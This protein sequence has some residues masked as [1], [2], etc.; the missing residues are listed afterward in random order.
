MKELIKKI[1]EI[2]KDLFK[3]YPFSISLSIL[4]SFILACF[5]ES[6]F[7]GDAIVFLLVF[8]VGVLFSEICFS[9]KTSLKTT[10]FII[11]LI[12]AIFANKYVLEG[13]ELISK[14]TIIYVIALFILGLIKY[15]K[16]SNLSL[17]EYATRVWSNLFK[18]HLVFSV[19][20][21][22]IMMISLIIM[23][24]FL[25][26]EQ[27]LLIVRLELLL[28]GIYYVPS[29]IYSFD[30]YK[31]KPWDF[32]IFILKN[33]TSAILVLAFGI[34]YLYMLKILITWN[35]PSNAIFRIVGLLF[36]LGL[37]LW[38]MINSFKDDNILVKISKKLP[39]AF[40]PLIALQIYSLAIRIA[41]NG[42]TVMR[43]IG[44]MLI[45]IEILYSIINIIKEDKVYTIGYVIIAMVIVGLVAPK[46][47]A[48]DVAVNSQYKTLTKLLNKK[49]LSPKEHSRLY[50][51]YSYLQDFKEGK[52]YLVSLSKE[53][54]D[55]IMEAK[56]VEYNCYYSSEPLT[57]YNVDIKGFNRLSEF[58]VNNSSDNGSLNELHE[59]DIKGNVVD[60]YSYVDKLI[61]SED[62]YNYVKE[63]KIIASENYKIY[64]NEIQVCIEEN[65][66]K[67]YT[68]S[69]YI[70][71]K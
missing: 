18:A 9:N 60:F 42:F 4:V 58:E 37:P 14:F 41:S 16:N 13:N 11:S 28:S 68:I 48:V 10:G 1:L 52:K 33:F 62:D 35:I 43:Y 7:I 50:S 34:I 47:N 69:G 19:L 32:I 25:S 40:I 30:S 67:S 3:R 66:L 6:D 64:V 63:S 49:I 39:L 44:V 70:L 24:L 5:L 36:I 59:V 2:P 29:L 46:I 27:E 17:G 20:S 71:E 53:D 56:E 45:I 61:K 55:F 65:N 38:I 22:G 26:E 21:T 31:E 23:A 15:Y 54:V 8:P 57:L 51:A 12:I